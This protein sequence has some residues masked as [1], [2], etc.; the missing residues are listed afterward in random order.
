[1]VSGRR[2]ASAAGFGA[3]PRTALTSARLRKS[4]VSTPYVFSGSAWACSN[5]PAEAASDPRRAMEKGATA[6][7]GEEGVGGFHGLG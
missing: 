5:K 6:D 2:L 7:V 1:M 3:L 4:G